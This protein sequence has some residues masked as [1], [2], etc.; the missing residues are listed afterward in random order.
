VTRGGESRLLAFMASFPSNHARAVI[1]PLPSR[2]A[3]RASPRD[4][5]KATDACTV[6]HERQTRSG[7]CQQPAT[8]ALTCGLAPPAPPKVAVDACAAHA[9]GDACS[10]KWEHG[11]TVNGA[12]TAAADGTLACA[13]ACHHELKDEARRTTEPSWP[14]SLARLRLL[15]VGSRV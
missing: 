13:P 7:T 1:L 6:T 8:G 11:E 12:C 3:P 2:A 9:K 10:F 4:G 14:P 15:P 5:R